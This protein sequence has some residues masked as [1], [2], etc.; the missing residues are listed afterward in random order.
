MCAIRAGMLLL[1]SV[2]FVSIGQAQTSYT[3]ERLEVPNS[4]YTFAG[5]MNRHGTIAG[6]CYLN[7][8][9]Q[10]LFFAREGRFKTFQLPLS[11]VQSSVTGINSRDD[12]IGTY[13]DQSTVPHAYLLKHNGAF[14]NVD[15]SA[16][17]AVRTNPTAINAQGDVV[18]VYYDVDFN[19]HAYLFTHGSFREFNVT[20]PG[21]TGTSPTGINSRGVI[22]GTYA[23]NGN[24]YGFV[25]ERGRTSTFDD[26]PGSVGTTPIGISDSGE[27]VGFA[28]T[29][30]QTAEWP[31]VHGF[32]YDH[33]KFSDFVPV[34]PDEPPQPF[35]SNR[36]I[37]VSNTG[38][39]L[40]IS[41][42]NKGAMEISFLARP[43]K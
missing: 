30:G 24:S 39:V 38:V 23:A 33:G 40:G 34:F 43:A 27:I 1:C 32:V 42:P 41:T 31:V 35:L 9:T 17:G 28:I 20:V 4:A 21:A 7:D 5:G 18:G 13:V 36:G 22:V 14:S 26:E 37:A 10:A 11:G 8:G 6:T 2:S 19:R 12:I 15:A 25:H 29:A 16:L 3:F